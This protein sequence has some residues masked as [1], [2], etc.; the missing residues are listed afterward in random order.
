MVV[1]YDQAQLE[2]I[3]GR[4]LT[5]VPLTGTL[6]NC[7]ARIFLKEQSEELNQSVIRIV[8]TAM[9]RSYNDF[10]GKH[11]YLVDVNGDIK[12]GEKRFESSTNYTQFDPEREFFLFRTEHIVH[13]RED[14]TGKIDS[15]IYFQDIGALGMG[16]EYA[17]EQYKKNGYSYPSPSKIKL[18]LP[19]IPR[20]SELVAGEGVFGQ[21]LAITIRRKSSTLTNT[22]RYAIG[23][24]TG[25]IASNVSTSHTWT[26]PASLAVQA[27]NVTALVG[28]LYVDTYSGS[29]NLGTTSI[30]VT[31]N[32]PDSFRPSLTGFTLIDHNTAASALIPGG[33]TFVQI[34][35]NIKVHFGQSSGS[36]GSTI[37]GYHAEIVGRNQS[38]HANGGALGIMNF[39]GTATIRAKV[40]DSRG[41]ESNTIER[42]VTVLEYFLPTLHFEVTRTGATAE[43][44]T[45]NR[46]ARIAPLMVGGVQK[47]TM[48]LAFRT[49]ALG[50]NTYTTNNGSA[51]GTWSTVHQLTNSTAN[52]AGA[53]GTNNSFVVVGTISDKFTSTDFSPPPV[54]TEKVTFAYDKD[55]RF[56]VGKIPEL[57]KPG[58]LDVAGDIYA[59]GKLIQQHQLTAGD[60]VLGYGKSG[61]NANTTYDTGY[62]WTN[63]NVPGGD[64][65]FLDVVRVSGLESQQTFRQ[66]NG[67]RVWS[68]Y[69][70]H[71]TGNWTG[72]VVSGLDQF[73][74]I[75]A[76]YSSTVNT[77]PQ[78]SLGGTWQS[79]GTITQN[80]NTIYSWK[81]TG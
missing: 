35:S 8:F 73:Y 48:S 76:V 19:R 45:V 36:H 7:K 72:W 44:L 42:T 21:N 31:F 40:I 67:S 74:P 14:G 41:R 63:Q 23:S 52:L 9:G 70:H 66:R 71:Q 1:L 51:S 38:T 69:R 81:R 43:T 6:N 56:A 4:Y 58:S 29:T 3:D 46:S 24:S 22:I 64:W 25:V 18:D 13:H 17:Y 59:G 60:P 53:F 61:V 47:N 20:L 50:S 75:G 68:R 77:S 26:I 57:G 12:R 37:T 11:T 78:P 28:T 79:L 65:G 10:H 2:A 34:M 55:G 27:P 33:Q 32:V 62:Y 49:A 80:G 5:Y 39:N 30:A 15:I 16:L 54:S